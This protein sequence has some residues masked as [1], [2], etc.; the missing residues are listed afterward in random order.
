[1]RRPRVSLHYSEVNLQVEDRRSILFFLMGDSLPYPSSF[2]ITAECPG[3]RASRPMSSQFG[4]HEYAK[5]PRIHSHAYVCLTSKS[6]DDF[7]LQYAL[8]IQ[9][10]ISRDFYI[11]IFLSVIHTSYC[12]TSQAFVLLKKNYNLITS[13][14]HFKLLI[15]NKINFV[16]IIIHSESMTFRQVNIILLK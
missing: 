7:E 3:K 10:S 16:V 11:Y 14:N 6:V 5:M 12:S 8:W 4:Q 13:M 15:I 9:A 1:M 2:L